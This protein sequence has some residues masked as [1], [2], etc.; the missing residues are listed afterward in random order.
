MSVY[1][2]MRSPH[3]TIY[4]LDMDVVFAVVITVSTVRVDGDG[5]A[6]STVVDWVRDSE[7][8]NM[9]VFPATYVP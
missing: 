4:S 3:V 9:S 8:M 5:V 6:V 7:L 1:A 2:W